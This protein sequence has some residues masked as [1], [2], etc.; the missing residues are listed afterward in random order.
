[1]RKRKKGT[2]EDPTLDN[3]VPLPPD[4]ILKR[5][6]VNHPDHYNDGK[7]E[8]IDFIEDQKLGFHLG[9]A[10]KYISRAGKKDPAKTVEDLKKAAWYIQR[11][12]DRLT[13]EAE[14]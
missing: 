8:V 13:K 6:A 10:V 5:E 7:I 1:M 3:L 2:L 4:V 14:T 12:L 9:N 11:E